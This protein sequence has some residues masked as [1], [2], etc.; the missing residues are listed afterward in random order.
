MEVIINK[1]T[2]DLT[3][4]DQQWFKRTRFKGM[5]ELTEA[6]SVT[7]KPMFAVNTLSSLAEFVFAMLVCLLS[8]AA[9]SN[10]I[11]YIVAKTGF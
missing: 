10:G 5:D 3:L 7:L 6:S 8:L 4:G 2:L 9:L 11:I 1:H